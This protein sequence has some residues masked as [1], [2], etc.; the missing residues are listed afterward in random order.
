MAV[1]G[2]PINVVAL[3]REG[4]PENIVQLGQVLFTQY[5][6]AFQAAG[7]LLLV[8]MI[9][10]I[11]LTHRQR[12]PHEVSVKRQNIGQQVNRTRE[13]AMELTQPATGKGAGVT[14][15]EGK[16]VAKKAKGN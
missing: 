10:A 7:L 4:A 1:H 12:G 15:W 11:G 16:S 2:A 6:V 14:H 3:V 9:G 13:E 5:A 8:A